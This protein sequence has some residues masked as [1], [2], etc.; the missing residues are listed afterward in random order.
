MGGGSPLPSK[1]GPMLL[2]PQVFS[3]LFEGPL[4]TLRKKGTEIVPLGV[5]LCV[6]IVPQG[7]C[8]GTLFYECISATGDKFIPHSPRSL[9]PHTEPLRSRQNVPQDTF[10]FP[11]RKDSLR[12]WHQ[13]RPELKQN[14]LRDTFGSTLYLTE[15]HSWAKDGR[16]H[17]LTNFLYWVIIVLFDGLQI[18]CRPFYGKMLYYSSKDVN[19]T[20]T[21]YLTELHS[22]AN[23]GRY[24]PL[25]NFLYWVIIALFDGLQIVCRPSNKTTV[26]PNIYNS[27]CWKLVFRAF[28]FMGMFDWE[29]GLIPLWLSEARVKSF[30]LQTLYTAC[31]LPIINLWP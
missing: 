11:Q 10:I 16:Y 21:L 6:A 24:H 28:P 15:L 13:S 18:V 4:P 2:T 29:G 17:P 9:K 8:F 14:V 22:W 3:S 20:S 7:Y 12:R 1:F 19:M 25:T 31:L 26:A 27:K 30:K 23:D 5:L